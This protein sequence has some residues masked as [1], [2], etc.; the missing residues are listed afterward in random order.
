MKRYGGSGR[1]HPRFLDLG[2]SLRYVASF[3]PR[4]LYP[5]GKG[6]CYPLDRRLGEPQSR[7]V[8][9]GEVKFFT[10]PGLEL[11]PLGHPAL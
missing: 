3:T 1:M 10:L 2:T 4:P 5:R 8:R 9:Y 11:R 6:P 7:S